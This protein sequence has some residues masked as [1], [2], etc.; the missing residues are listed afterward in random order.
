LAF[1]S[2]ICPGGW[3]RRSNQQI[4]GWVLL[5]LG[6]RMLAIDTSSTEWPTENDTDIRV[7]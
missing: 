1:L 6:G 7:G 3:F 2:A 4:G 5:S